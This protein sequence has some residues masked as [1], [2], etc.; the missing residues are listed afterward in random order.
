MQVICRWTFS[1]ASALCPSVP[2]TLEK[3]GGGGTWPSW[4]YGS[5]AS[6]LAYTA[7]WQGVNNYPQGYSP[8]PYQ[9]FNSNLQP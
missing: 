3:W 6:V 5:G 7:W 1:V 4:I 9:K 8:C 2:P